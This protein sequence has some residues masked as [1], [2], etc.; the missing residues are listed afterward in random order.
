MMRKA[1]RKTL[2]R[3][4]QGAKRREKIRIQGNKRKHLRQQQRH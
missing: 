2:D 1:L 3:I 4:D